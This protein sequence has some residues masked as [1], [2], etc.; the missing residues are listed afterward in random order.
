MTIISRKWFS[1]A[2]QL[3][4]LSADLRER[5]LIILVAAH[6]IC[7]FRLFGKEIIWSGAI[8]YVRSWKEQDL[9]KEFDK[10]QNLQA[11]GKGMKYIKRGFF[12]ERHELGKTVIDI[13]ILL[14]K[15]HYIIL[16]L[17]SSLKSTQ[18]KFSFIPSRDI[19]NLN[20][21]KNEY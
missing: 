17:T 16:L 4:T 18:Y 19:C 20:K 6:S 14:F 7:N 21:T 10:L 15:F 12:T 3:C 1:A 13:V 8:D 11:L 9:E 5:L 2:S